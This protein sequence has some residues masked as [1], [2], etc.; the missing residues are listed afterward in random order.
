MHSIP[1]AGQ[2]VFYESCRD[3]DKKRME[4]MRDIFVIEIAIISYSL[5][6]FFNLY[7]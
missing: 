7:L 2:E 3:V 6:I 1:E 4:E 5:K